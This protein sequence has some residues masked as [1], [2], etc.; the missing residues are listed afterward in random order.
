MVSAVRTNRAPATLGGTIIGEQIHELEGPMN[1]TAWRTTGIFS[2]AAALFMVLGTGAASADELAGQT[3]AD[4]SA[5]IAQNGGTAVVATVSG[6]EL[7][8]DDCVVTSS[9]KSNSRDSSGVLRQP[10]V[11]LVNLNCNA[12]VAAAGKPGNSA[13]TP[14][15]KE[16]KKLEAQAAA[17]TANPD[18]CMDSAE[19]IAYCQKICERTGQCELP[20]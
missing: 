12:T 2:A 7:S 11:V 5:S 17:I 18:L 4:A 19:T 13:A 14:A 20:S 3:Y 9:R 10:T 8:T 1:T 6:G 16:Q 15:G